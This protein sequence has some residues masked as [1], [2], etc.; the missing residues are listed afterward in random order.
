MAYSRVAPSGRSQNKSSAST[1]TRPSVETKGPRREP[2]LVAAGGGLHDSPVPRPRASEL[3]RRRRRRR[4]PPRSCIRSGRPGCAR[5]SR[6]R[7]PSA[8]CCR[9]QNKNP[10]GPVNS[11]A[12]PDLSRLR[13]L[14]SSREVMAPNHG[15]RLRLKS[16]SLNWAGISQNLGQSLMNHTIL[17]K[18]LVIL[19]VGLSSSPDDMSPPL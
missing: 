18:S 7:R 16:Q 14:S 10:R 4:A 17:A 1:A 9:L 3:G 15:P 13:C 8:G 5:C 2:Q 6:G 12:T 19:S 11:R